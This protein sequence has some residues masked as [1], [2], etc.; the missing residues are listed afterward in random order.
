MNEVRM[1]KKELSQI[2]IF[3]AIVNKKMTQREASQLVRLST[4]QIIRK[5]KRYKEF[6]I[7]GLIHK[8]RGKKGNRAI[9]E[10][11]KQKI[12]ELLQ[13]K[14]LGYGP[15]L[16]AEKLYEYENILINHETL[17]KFMI[18]HGLWQKRQ[19]KR[20]IYIWRERKHHTGEMLLIDGSEHIWFGNDYCTLIACIDDA[21]SIIDLHFDQEETIK[22]V[23]TLTKSYFKKYGKPRS[24]YTDRGKVFKVNNA[25]D[26]KKHFT[27]YQRMLSEMD[28]E[29][30]HAYSPQAKGRV[31]RLFRT[32]QDWLPKELKLR[33]IKTISKANKFLQEIFIEYANKKLVVEP[34]S[35]VDLHQ[36]IDGYDLNSIFCLKYQRTLN[37]DN[38]ITYKNRYFLLTKKQPVMLKRYEKITVNVHFDGTISLTAQG[39][40]LDY[41]EFEKRPKKEK[42]PRQERKMSTYKPPM[43]HPWRQYSKTTGVVK[44]DISIELKK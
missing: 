15:T 8:S 1:S 26:G 21:T 43:K 31:E 16:A 12:I 18:A 41:K 38:S 6:G 2:T 7:E 39:Q 28:I 9:S 25:K 11:V 37:N 32:L 29:I 22:S 19:R 20:K 34:K 33:D 3:D 44:G 4:R 13:G 42:E 5:A 40:R 17:R 14:Y 10:E 23:S 27:Q 30:K 35:E 36:S 24:I